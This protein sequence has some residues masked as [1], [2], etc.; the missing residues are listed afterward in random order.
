MDKTRLHDFIAASQP[1]I[2]QLD[3]WRADRPVFSGEWNGYAGTDCVHVMSVTKSVMALLTGIAIDRGRIRGVDEP[4]LRFFP[5]YRVKRGENTIRETTI[6][7]LL[8]MRAPWKCKGDP[9]SKVCSS[10]DW[11]RASLDFLGGRKGLSDEFRYQ[12]VCLHVLSGILYRAT[13]RKTAD[14]A[15]ECLFG[16]L[17]IASRRNFT[18][19]TAEEH[20]RFTV[21]KG[22]KPPVWFADPEGLATPGYG[23]CLSARDMA[24]IGRLC[25]AEGMWEGKRIVSPGWIREMTRARPIGGNRFRGMGYGFLWWIVHPGKKAYAAI[26]NSGNV[27]YVDP[28]RETVVAVSSFFK[29][30]VLD[31]IDFIERHLLP[32]LEE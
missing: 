10:R 31:R 27:I 28:D 13:G 16:P 29:P 30:T 3:V 24:K 7:H 8:T 17:G 32:A 21:D 23:L 4:V 18:A 9:W 1:N 5:D 22:P 11:T 20:R 6:R 26:G 15:N 2:C 25:L 14:F 19:A 12:T